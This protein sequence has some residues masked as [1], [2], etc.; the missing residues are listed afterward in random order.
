MFFAILGAATLSA[1]AAACVLARPV[2]LA[3]AGSSLLYG[4]A[5]LVTGYGLLHRKRLALFAYGIW[6][7][8]IPLSLIVSNEPLAT[9][10]WLIPVYLVALA[11]SYLVGRAIWRVC[12]GAA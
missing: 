4:A 12:M 10:P 6:C 3:A 7:M 1:L 11:I 5:A 9:S 2:P 8:S